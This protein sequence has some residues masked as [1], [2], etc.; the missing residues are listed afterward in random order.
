M[1]FSSY[2]LYLEWTTTSS[3]QWSPFFHTL[4]C[5]PVSTQQMECS[6]T[7]SRFYYTPTWE[8]FTKWLTTTFDLVPNLQG[9]SLCDLTTTYLFDL[10]AHLSFSLFGATL[11]FSHLEL[12]RF[13]SASRFWHLVSLYLE[14]FSCPKTGLTVL[15]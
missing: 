13:F 3:L 11:D 2:G 10:I 4:P 6:F 9:P 12:T 8:S 7:D 14:H 15:E 1:Y 5:N